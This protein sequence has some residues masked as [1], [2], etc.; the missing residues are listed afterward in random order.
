MSLSERVVEMDGKRCHVSCKEQVKKD[1]R[2]KK[3]LDRY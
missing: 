3:G 2:K 1:W